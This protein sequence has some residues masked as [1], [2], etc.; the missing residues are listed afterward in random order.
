MCVLSAEGG[1]LQLEESCGRLRAYPGCVLHEA[2]C[3][4]RLCR[5]GRCV[6]HGAVRFCGGAWWPHPHLDA[7]AKIEPAACAAL[8]LCA[9]TVT[10]GP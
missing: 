2:A 4:K 6:V 3:Y 8:V 10:P 7:H 9:F 5:A 1:Q